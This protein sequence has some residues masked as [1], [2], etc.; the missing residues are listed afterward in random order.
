[1]INKWTIDV[2]I[3]QQGQKTLDRQRYQFPKDWI[4]YEQIE[5]EWSSFNEIFNKK[6]TIIHDERGT[7]VVGSVRKAERALL[8]T[9]GLVRSL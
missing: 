6:S 9:G 3:Y 7:W 4:Y 1:M 5:G 8:G 2:D